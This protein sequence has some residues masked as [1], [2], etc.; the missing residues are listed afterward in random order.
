VKDRRVLLVRH[1][2]VEKPDYGNWL[3]PAGSVER[4]EGVDEALKREMREETG[5]GIKI[6]RKIAEHI[7]PYTGDKLINFLCIPSTLTVETS[8]ELTEAKWFSVKEIQ[9][10]ENIHPGLKHF[11]IQGFKADSFKE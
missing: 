1:A 3:L 8:S 9:R 4:G 2:S 10:L 11:L 5:L 6:V 7:D